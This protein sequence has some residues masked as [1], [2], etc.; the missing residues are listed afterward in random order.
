MKR[1][2]LVYFDAGGG[3]RNAAIAL[4]QVLQQSQLPW[5]VHLVNLQEILDSIDIVRQLTGLRI[6]DAYNRML[7]NGWTLGSPQLMRVLQGIIWLFHP[8]TVRLLQKFW[9]ELQPD[10]GMRMNAFFVLRE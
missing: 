1:I 8:K 3:H 2:A 10:W 5:D 7:Q 6:Q 9:G 4:Q